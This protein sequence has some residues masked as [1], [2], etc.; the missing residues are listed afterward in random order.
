MAQL[1]RRFFIAW[2]PALLVLL[3]MAGRWVAP[4]AVTFSLNVAGVSVSVPVVTLGMPMVALL[5]GLLFLFGRARR[6]KA[7]RREMVS[8][9]AR[10]F[11]SLAVTEKGAIGRI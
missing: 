7:Q 3:W 4:D 8:A 2:C 9:F 11:A 6:Q 1:W 5:I 10:V